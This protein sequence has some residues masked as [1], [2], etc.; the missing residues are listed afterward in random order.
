MVQSVYAGTLFARACICVMDD[1]SSDGT[2]FNRGWL[3][4]YDGW[5]K[6]R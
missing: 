4:L 2:L 5:C 3:D 1:V 6:F